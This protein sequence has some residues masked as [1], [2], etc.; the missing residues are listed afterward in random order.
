LFEDNDADGISNYR[1]ENITLTDPDNADSDSDG[2][3]DPEDVFIHET[4]PNIADIDEDGLND[5]EEIDAATDPRVADS[6]GDGLSD[7][8]EVKTYSSN[9]NKADTD[10]DGIADAAE[11]AAGLDINAAENIA[12]AVAFLIQELANRPPVDGFEDAIAEARASGRNDVTSAPSEYD[13]YEKEAY[14]AVVAERDARPTLAQYSEVLV[15]RDARPSVVAYNAVIAD[16]DSRP[17]KEAYDTVVSERDARPT[18]EEVKD[19]RLG[20]VLLLPD[21]ATNKVRLRFCIEES[22]GLGQW[23][24]RE[25]EAEVDVPLAPG[26]K[27]FRFSVKE[28]E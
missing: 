12:D 25:E 18:L 9:P 11:V 10:G 2:L 22:N 3:L 20:S 6:D 7:G 27:F 19:G 28:N 26:K 1:E 24:T 17:T 8:L 21:T 5:S 13:L 16:R 23:I 4:D 14:N 15:E